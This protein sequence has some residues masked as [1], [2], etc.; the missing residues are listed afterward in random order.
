[1][2]ASKKR[3]QVNLD[4]MLK[5]IYAHKADGIPEWYMKVRMM[6]RPTLFQCEIMMPFLFL[7]P[8]YDPMRLG[9]VTFA[10]M[11]QIFQ[12]GYQRDLYPEIIFNAIDSMLLRAAVEHPL[13]YDSM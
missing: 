9:Y 11:E 5:F 2:L 6:R 12:F 8:Q 3:Y 7:H 4:D 13:M 10:T 1:M